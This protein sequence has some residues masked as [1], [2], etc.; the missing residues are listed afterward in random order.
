MCNEICDTTNQFQMPNVASTSFYVIRYKE[1]PDSSRQLRYIE[2]L[3]T[4][5]NHQAMMEYQLAQIAI[6]PQE[7]DER[8]STDLPVRALSWSWP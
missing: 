4:L 5:I 3:C 2:V 8:D 7:R 1:I 6:V